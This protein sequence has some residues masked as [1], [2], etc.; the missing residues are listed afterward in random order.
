MP[1]RAE[2]AKPAQWFVYV[3]RCADNSLYTGVALDVHKRLDEHN[4][5]TKN[6]AKY[7]H[8]RRPVELVYQEAADSRSDA[9]KREY[10]IRN[11]R[12]SQKENL[13]KIKY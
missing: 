2:Q 12:K 13:I 3:L 9:C 6:G 5:I 10:V 7:T 1:S 11:L 4:G 8:A